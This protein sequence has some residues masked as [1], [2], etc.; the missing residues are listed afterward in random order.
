MRWLPRRGPS[1]GFTL[2]FWAK[3]RGGL[4][5][6]KAGALEC[7]EEWQEACGLFC[8]QGCIFVHLAPPPCPACA[9][10]GGVWGACCSMG[11]FEAHGQRR[12]LGVWGVAEGAPRCH[13]CA[14]RAA[15]Q[16][17]EGG[18]AAR[19]AV[20]LTAHACRF[21]KSPLPT[22][23]SLRQESH[24]PPP[25]RKH[26]PADGRRERTQ[27]RLASP[28]AA[29]RAWWRMAQRHGGRGVKRRGH[30]CL[31][32]SALDCIGLR[33]ELRERSSLSLRLP[34]L[35]C[36]CRIAAGRYLGSKCWSTRRS[37]CGMGTCGAARRNR[38]HRCRRTDDA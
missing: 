15:C 27:G 24:R 36:A 25:Q 26:A 19:G 3:Q 16:A 34:P 10:A 20:F 37:R 8:S 22:R 32:Q 33:R 38:Q 28:D 35:R 6:R 23:R 5:W 13:S 29:S 14:V 4:P 31:S 18:M 12:G 7:V 21:L 30:R 9:C 17:Q 1:S 2:S 11:F